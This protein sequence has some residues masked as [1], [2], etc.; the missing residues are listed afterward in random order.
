MS[1][2]PDVD[3]DPSDKVAFEAV[4]PD[5]PTENGSSIVDLAHALDSIDETSPNA[6]LNATTISDNNGGRIILN[7]GKGA[8]KSSKDTSTSQSLN[9]FKGKEK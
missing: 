7:E 3:Y 6:E 4:L 2:D 9:T 1:I 8:E 5:D